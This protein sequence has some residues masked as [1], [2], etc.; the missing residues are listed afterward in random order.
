M[1][2]AAIIPV[3]IVLLAPACAL[4]ALIWSDNLLTNPG[5]ETGVLAPWIDG[6]H[7]IVSQS[8]GEHTGPV[9]PHSGN[10]FF[11]MAGARAGS[12]GQLVIE[13]LYQDVDVRSYA[14]AIDRG[15]LLVQANSWLHTEDSPDHDY[16]DYAQLSLYFLT[17]S[18]GRIGTLTTGLVQSPNDIWIAKA[19]DGTAPFGTRTLRLELLGRKREGGWINAF[20]DDAGVKVAE[21]PEPATLCLLSLASLQFLR[22]RKF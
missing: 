11:N 2:R 10:W 9:Y 12:A 19:V 20:F 8:Q 6:S 7:T 17:E 15:M 13:T 22:R 3:L 16:A 5:A 4:S 21:V 14:P 18:G 1:K